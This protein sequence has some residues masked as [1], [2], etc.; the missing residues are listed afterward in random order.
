M[1][2][3][4][5]PCSAGPRCDA[6]P[7]AEARHT[8]LASE[9][10][11]KVVHTRGVGP[12]HCHRKGHLTPGLALQ[13]AHHAN[14]LR[15]LEANRRL[16]ARLQQARPCLAPAAQRAT[17]PFGLTARPGGRLVLTGRPGGHPQTRPVQG[18]LTYE[19]LLS[20]PLTA[21]APAQAHGQQRVRPRSSAC[22]PA[23][24]PANGSLGRRAAG[25]G[26]AGRRGAG[27]RGPP[28]AAARQR[29][30]AARRAAGAPARR[31][32][33]RHARCA[34]RGARRPWAGHGAAAVAGA[35]LLRMAR[36]WAHACPP[37]VPS[38]PLAARVGARR[39]T[40]RVAAPKRRTCWVCPC[41]VKPRRS[42]HDACSRGGPT[43]AAALLDGGRRRGAL[44]AALPCL[45]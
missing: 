24:A 12:L 33:P 28:G 30:A 9:P 6:K 2:T 43:T 19:H 27:Q 44:W 11:S 3:R 13:E 20:V 17:T 39:G 21:Q 15:A 29:D 34:A 37:R 42:A 25:A 4:P 10:V 38:H 5:G 45:L 1:R 18:S 7:A 31:A 8:S 14:V 40:H 35:A 41:S 36:A 26:V 32:L 23:A 16:Q 22:R